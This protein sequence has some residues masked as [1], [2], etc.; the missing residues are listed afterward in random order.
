MLERRGG[1][2]ARD[3]PQNGEGALRRAAAETRRKAQ[4]PDSDRI[5]PSDGRGPPVGG[6]PLRTRGAAAP[7]TR[8]PAGH[9]EAAGAPSELR[10]GRVENSIQTTSA[11]RWGGR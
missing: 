2:A 6:A 10:S 7:L 3:L 8:A 11:G 4:T 9:R 5:P 1:S